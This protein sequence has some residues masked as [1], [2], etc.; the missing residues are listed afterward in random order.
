MTRGDIVPG[1]GLGGT[2]RRGQPKAQHQCLD[3]RDDHPVQGKGSLLI[4]DR[5]ARRQAS[6]IVCVGPGSHPL[7][8]GRNSGRTCL[9]R[10]LSLGFGTA[11]NELKGRSDKINSRG[12]KTG[13]Y[14]SVVQDRPDVPRSQRRA[15]P[16]VDPKND[17]QPERCSDHSGQ[18]SKGSSCPQA[19]QARKDREGREYSKAGYK[20]CRESRTDRDRRVA[21]SRRSRFQ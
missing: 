5:S 12:Q 13:N 11:L 21:E 19:W 15:V 4:W 10:L 7:A 20:G 6:D 2:K 16:R 9:P 8:S 14:P 1:R 18:I 3:P 17:D